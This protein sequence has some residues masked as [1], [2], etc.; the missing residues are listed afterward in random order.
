MPRSAEYSR[1]T[2]AAIVTLRCQGLG[3]TAI[4]EQ[5]PVSPNGA[6]TFMKRLLDQA[7]I[8]HT[9]APRSLPL[10][11]LLQLLPKKTR[12]GR[13]RR[14]RFPEGSDVANSLVET[15]VHEDDQETPHRPIVGR[16]AR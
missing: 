15:A 5:L 16:V 1:E 9:V 11:Q 12:R 7:G 10:A 13:R 8:A 6:F 14:E 2:R 4:S 3:W